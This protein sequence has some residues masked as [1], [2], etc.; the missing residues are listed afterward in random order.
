MQRYFLTSEHTL[1]ESD[2]HHIIKVLR[3]KSGD[4]IYVCDQVCHEAEIIIN[5]QHVSF[6]KL[7]VLKKIQK[8]H[9]TLVQGLPKTPKVETT[10]KYATMVGVS[11]IIICPMQYSQSQHLPASQKFDRYQAIA[12]EA[13]ELAH[14]DDMPVV[15]GIVQIKDLDF[16]KTMYV[17][18]ETSKT[19]IEDDIN[20][21]IIII[22]GPEG[23]I[24]PNERDFLLEKGVKPITL[25]PLI[26][27]S[28]IAGVIAIGKL[29]HFDKS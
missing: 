2:Q 12:K 24:H 6:K 25:G 10:I 28:E 18:D 15:K 13:A 19:Y 16:T 17:L 5:H 9:I 23:G 1:S 27:S 29:I 7:H 20:Q 26:L 14:R 22:V 4:H 11:E 21:D 8:R 3:M